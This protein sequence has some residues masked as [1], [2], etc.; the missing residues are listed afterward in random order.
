MT[1]EKCQLAIGKW[2]F[3]LF[4]IFGIQ[5][6]FETQSNVSQMERSSPVKVSK[7]VRLRLANEIG[8]SPPTHLAFIPIEKGQALII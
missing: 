7:H 4:S 1:I 8:Q 5:F 2:A 6:M 3:S